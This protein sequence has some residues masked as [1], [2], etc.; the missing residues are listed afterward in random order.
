MLGQLESTIKSLELNL[1]LEPKSGHM[2]RFNYFYS[3]L[4]V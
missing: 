1:V 3:Y 2:L 4:S